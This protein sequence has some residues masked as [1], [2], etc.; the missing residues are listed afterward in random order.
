MYYDR[1]LDSKYNPSGEVSKRYPHPNNLPSDPR[2]SAEQLTADYLGALKTHLLYML[3]RQ[4]GDLQAKETPLQFIL[5]V[6]AVWS[7]EA[8]EK[9]LQAAEKAG[10][11]SHAPI[12]MISEPVC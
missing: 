7:D 6:P 2:H 9:T 8:K 4:L 3:Q 1:D 11:G 5:T 12:L 10:L